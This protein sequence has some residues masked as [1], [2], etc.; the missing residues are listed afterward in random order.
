MG[1]WDSEV[2]P[3]ITKTGAKGGLGHLAGSNFNYFDFEVTIG[4]DTIESILFGIEVVSNFYF[5]IEFAVRLWAHPNPWV[6]LR[7][8]PLLMDFLAILPFLIE[9][10]CGL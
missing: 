6:Y 1:K 8:L 7:T 9:L 2:C 5:I 10:I 3:L 4:K